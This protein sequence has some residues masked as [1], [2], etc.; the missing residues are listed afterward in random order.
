MSSRMAGMTTLEPSPLRR[1][2]RAW[3]RPR[4]E[5]YP[6]RRDGIG[7]YAVLVSEVMLQQTQAARVAAAF[8][9]FLR[10]FP[11]V[12]SLAAASPADV[13]RAWSGLGYHRRA[14]AL[15]EAARTIVRVHGGEV[16]G[17]P[18]ALQ[19]LPGV[20]PYTASAVASIAFGRPVVAMDVNVRRVASRVVLGR[21]P[22]ERDGPRI[23]AAARVLLDRRDP[24]A[25]NQAMM[26]LGREVCRPTPRCE[27]CPFEPGCR[28]R[29]AGRPGRPAADP[30]QSPF[31]GSNR[32]VRGRIVAV[33]RERPSAGL[34][35]LAAAT[36]FGADRIGSAVTGLVRDGIVERRGRS[37]RLPVNRPSE[38][39]NREP[40]RSS[41]SFSLSAATRPEG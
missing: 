10:R 17:D 35:G 30:K 3:Y 1:A 7:P 36:G 29:S 18:E 15:H 16:P 14:V 38:R 19:H 32:Q 20:G 21:E 37:F 40:G 33:L 8:D 13:L 23:A 4:S 26:D 22:Q 28:F 12:S 11:N 34:S 24:A 27:V 31:E 41:D 2:L 6:W 9:G 5:G 25:W 39:S